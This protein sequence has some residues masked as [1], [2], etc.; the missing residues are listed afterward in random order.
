MRTARPATCSTVLMFLGAALVS[1]CNSDRA[2][3]SEAAPAGTLAAQDAKAQ[4]ARR[5]D[6]PR[7]ERSGGR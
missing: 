1:A 2:P 4:E 7:E 5:S 6:G 3:A